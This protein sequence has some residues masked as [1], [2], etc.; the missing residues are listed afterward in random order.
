M[1]LEPLTK[2]PEQ[3]LLEIWRQLPKD[4]QQ[5][6]LDFAKFMAHQLGLALPQSP[7]LVSAPPNLG[8]KLQGIRDRIVASETPLLSREQIEQ[9]VLDRRGGY[10]EYS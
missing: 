5:Q 1:T 10:Q 9:E 6:V 7:P 8:N 3:F 2:S 4:R